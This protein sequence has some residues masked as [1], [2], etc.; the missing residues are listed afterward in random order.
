MANNNQ[1]RA[2]DGDLPTDE[3]FGLACLANKPLSIR[4]DETEKENIAEVRA[5]LEAEHFELKKRQVKA[6]E[7]IAKALG[8]EGIGAKIASNIFEKPINVYGE[9]IG[10]AIQNQI[11][12]GQRGINT[13]DRR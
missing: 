7:Q 5:K 10:E 4:M 11:E 12:R 3:Y 2:I 6:L 8:E 13:Y 1:S 9:T